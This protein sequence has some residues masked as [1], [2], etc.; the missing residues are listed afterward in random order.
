MEKQ[1]LFSMQEATKEYNFVLFSVF[2]QT[3]PGVIY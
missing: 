3:V 2:L 1:K